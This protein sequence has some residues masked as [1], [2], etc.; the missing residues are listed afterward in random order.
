[1]DLVEISNSK[2]NLTDEKIGSGAYSSI[3]E[4][5][6]K[7]NNNNKYIVK[8]HSYEYKHEAINEIEALLKINKNRE[9]YINELTKCGISDTDSKITSV[10]DYYFSDD[11]IY[12]IFD[13]YTITLEE[14]SIKYN[15]K[16]NK[17]LPFCVSKKII[18]SMFLGL[19]ELSLSKLIHSDIKPNNI[20]IILNDNY[21]INKLFKEIKNKKISDEKFCNLIDIRYIDF[22]KVQSSKSIYKST[23]IQTLYYTPPEIIIGDRNYNSTTDSWAVCCIIHE[24]LTSQ[25]LFDVY[26]LNNKYGNNY[27]NYTID[28]IDESSLESTSIS[29]T[30]DDDENLD[31]LALLHIY[32]YLLG[33]NCNAKGDNISIFYPNNMLLGTCYRSNNSNINF[34]II[35]DMYKDNLYISN[36]LQIFNKIFVYDYNNRINIK[37]I[38]QY[39]K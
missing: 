30:T 23:N 34:N 12:T 17:V 28:E 27:L 26:N 35:R 15:K 33:D 8:T 18:N 19:Y 5:K 4:V 11:E 13:K 2:Y 9:K 32:R 7:F 16:F 29:D 22:N 25:Y 1:M 21:T 20:M 39:I 37:D 6:C 24:L 38:L 14:F 31:Y 36:I 10:I 3:H